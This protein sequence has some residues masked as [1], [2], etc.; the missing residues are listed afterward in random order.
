MW[1]NSAKKC[2][3]ILVHGIK[4][5]QFWIW[6]DLHD[7]DESLDRRPFNQLLVKFTM[8]EFLGVGSGVRSCLYNL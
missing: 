7:R 8:K 3:H 5:R 6:E 2:M 4:D 1:A